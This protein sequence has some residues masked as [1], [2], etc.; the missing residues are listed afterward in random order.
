MGRQVKVSSLVGITELAEQLG[1]DRTTVHQWR[2]RYK[3]FPE[4]VAV[5]TQ[6]H[7]YVMSDVVE[8]AV[9]RGLPRSGP[10]R[11]SMKEGI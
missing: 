7:V 6:A 1:V 3:D 2:H 10:G 11:P 5:L 4:P 9:K 8:W